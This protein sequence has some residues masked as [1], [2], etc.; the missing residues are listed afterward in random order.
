VLLVMRVIEELTILPLNDLTSVDLEYAYNLY[1][2]R[3]GDYLKIKIS[4]HRPDVEDFPYRVTRFGRQYLAD[5]IIQ[6][7]LRLKGE[8]ILIILTSSDI[9]TTGTNYVF[10]LA[11]KGCAVVSRARID[12]AFWKGVD[13]VYAYTYKG[14]PFFEKQ[15]GKVL[16]H[17]F[18]HTLGLPHCLNESCVMLY[19][20]SPFELYRKG[21]WF[22]QLC[23]EKLRSALGR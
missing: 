22:C 12:P 19:S 10:G 17:E 8:E 13:E 6:K 1:S 23:L 3:L 7:W 15:F 21:E 9:Y 14:R 11:V 2:S 4:N 20:N 16:I 5:A 18:G